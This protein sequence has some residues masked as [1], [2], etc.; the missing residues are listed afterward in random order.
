MTRAGLEPA[1]LALKVR[2]STTELPGHNSEHRILPDVM[3]PNWFA[4][5]RVVEQTR[6]RGAYPRRCALWPRPR[7]AS[8]PNAARTLELGPDRV[9]FYAP[10]SARIFLRRR[11]PY[12]G[13]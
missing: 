7:S 3:R 9:R 10:S 6:A 13:P 4:A 5:Q 1:T 12:S 8:R 2:C 11:S